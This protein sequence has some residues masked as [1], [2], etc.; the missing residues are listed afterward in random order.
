[1]SLTSVYFFSYQLVVVIRSYSTHLLVAINGRIFGKRKENVTR[2]CLKRYWMTSSHHQKVKPVSLCSSG[3]ETKRSVVFR[4]LRSAC[5]VRSKAQ[6][7][8]M[9][10]CSFFLWHQITL[11]PNYMRS[12]CVI[13]PDF[14]KSKN[15]MTVIMRSAA[16]SDSP[17]ST[18]KTKLEPGDARK[19]PPTHGHNHYCTYTHPENC[20]VFYTSWI[21]TFHFEVIFGL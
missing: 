19:P 7:S 13:H 17:P 6:L 11:I 20:S 14:F 10:L 21:F 16:K 5:P 12:S 3:W 9:M 1:M 8:I 4:V 15:R 2:V 18:F